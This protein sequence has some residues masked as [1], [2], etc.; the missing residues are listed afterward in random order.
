M[1]AKQILP[2]EKGVIGVN[3]CMIDKVLVLQVA[4]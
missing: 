3:I 4:I 2:V 1:Q